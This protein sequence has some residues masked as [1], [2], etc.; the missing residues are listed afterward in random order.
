MKPNVLP[1]TPLEYKNLMEQCWDADPLKRPDIRT[2][3]Y[4]MN[5][6]N[7]HYQNIQSELTQPEVN[8][9]YNNLKTSSKLFTSKVHQFENMPEPRNATEGISISFIYSL[10]IYKIIQIIKFFFLIKQ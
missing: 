3:R 2:I 4:K 6:I 1:G 10:I 7:L 9:T 5:E 8:K